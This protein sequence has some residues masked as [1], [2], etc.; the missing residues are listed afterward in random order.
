M[1]N[2][3]IIRSIHIRTSVEYAKQRDPLFNMRTQQHS[4][5]SVK[6]QWTTTTRIRKMLFHFWPE[7]SGNGD[8]YL[9]QR[10]NFQIIS[11]IHLSKTL[12]TNNVSHARKR[13]GVKKKNEEKLPANRKTSVKIC[14]I[15]YKK[16][17][18]LPFVC[19]GWIRSY[20]REYCALQVCR[21]HGQTKKAKWRILTKTNERTNEY[22][23]YETYL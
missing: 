18:Q 5:K 14:E 4:G 17:K 11:T 6:G 20:V 23:N 1:E 9:L 2:A 15:L 3:S 22:I 21:N 13:K 8:L 12:E 19:K 16:Y 10:W 7:Q